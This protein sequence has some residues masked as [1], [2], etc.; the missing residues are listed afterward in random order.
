MKRKK[1]S[2]VQKLKDK[3][4]DL[5]KE[6]CFLRDGRECQVKRYFPHLGPHSEILQ[7]DHMIS[8]KNTFLIYEP[9]NGTVV[10]K[11]CNGSKH[12]RP[13]GPVDQA[14]E[15]IR[16]MI[17][18]QEKVDQM[19]ALERSGKPNLDF[20]QVWYLEKIIEGLK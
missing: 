12:W 10:C 1:K 15:E 2:K 20:S 11:V 8:R 18:G 4:N 19:Y 13:K 3:A 7:V 5:W 14:I 16:I 6:A 17:E 9:K